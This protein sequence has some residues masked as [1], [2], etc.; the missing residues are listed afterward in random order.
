M[1]RWLKRNNRYKGFRAEVLN[2]STSVLNNPCRGWFTLYSFAVEEDFDLRQRFV[3]S[4]EESLVL[5]LADIGA[6]RDNEN[7]EEALLRIEKIIN[8]FYENGKDIILRIAYD[9]EGKGMEKE[10]SSFKMV[11]KHAEQIADFI[12]KNKEKIFL[13]QGLLIGRWG[14]MHTSKFTDTEKLKELNA[15]FEKVLKNDMYRAVRKPVQW[16]MIRFRTNTDDVKTDNLGIFNDGMFGS[17][18][19]LGTFDSTNKGD[20]SWSKAWN[21]EN[22]TEFIGSIACTVP[23]GGEALFGEGFVAVNDT[24]RYISELSKLRVTYLNGHYDE[25]LIEYWKKTAFIGKGIW[26]KSSCYDYIGSHLGYRFV[27][28]N[29]EAEKNGENIILKVKIENSGFADI[30]K[31]TC[32]YLAV[33]GKNESTKI[34]SENLNGCHPGETKEY[35]IEIPKT[36]GKVYIYAVYAG[37]KI[38]F[39]NEPVSTD[40]KILL[41]EIT[42]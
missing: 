5:I 27:I 28:R 15:V 34:F 14:E 31:E 23:V 8:Y 2:E 12:S 40:G 10:P 20:T 3:L 37:E 24:S 16:R 22:E 25:K 6:Y 30:Y 13:Y 41:G 18:S 35:S 38:Y 32:L 19:D 9:H 36:T 26:G 29:V 39:A 21:R 7:L 1:I 17:D 11:L 4:D 42:E 33:T